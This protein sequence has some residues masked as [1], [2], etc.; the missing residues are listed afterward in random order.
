MA[1]VGRAEST[2]LVNCSLPTSE[3]N[4][5]NT[6]SLLSHLET[7]GQKSATESFVA[8]SGKPKYVKGKD[9]LVQPRE[10]ANRS[11]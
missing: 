5:E 4:E 8:H 11:K 6:V 3:R 2:S 7:S 1:K 9:P 10:A